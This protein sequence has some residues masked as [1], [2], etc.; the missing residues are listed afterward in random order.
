MS[1]YYV[2]KVVKVTEREPFE[3]HSDIQP[4]GLIYEQT[5]KCLNLED[6]IKVVNQMGRLTYGQIDEVKKI[7]K[8]ATKPEKK[9]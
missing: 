6:I 2:V 8:E 9:K 1:S 7:V 4:K 5:V 3:S